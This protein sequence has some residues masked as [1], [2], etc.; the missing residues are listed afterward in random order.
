MNDARLFRQDLEQCRVVTI[1]D[2]GLEA[3]EQGRRTGR[4]EREVVGVHDE[5]AGCELDAL[6]VS[7]TRDQVSIQG[8]VLQVD[9]E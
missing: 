7:L 2:H 3:V 4:E 6:W 5:D 8:D 9:V 1:L